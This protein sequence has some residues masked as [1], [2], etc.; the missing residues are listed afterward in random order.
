MKL[1][2]TKNQY[3][4]LLKMIYLGNWMGASAAD[5]TTKEF[6]DFEQYALSL[7][8]DFGFHGYVGF[9]E[10]ENTH[11]PTEEFEEKT[12]VVDI[13]GD[14]NMHTV[15]EEMVLSLARRDLV[16]QY[17]EE[18]VQE[19]ADEELM[20]KEYPFV[21]KYEEEFRDRG[22]QNLVISTKG[23]HLA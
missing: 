16:A 23:L 22:F 7:A 12:G 18:K 4:T 2:I 9:D 8:K 5:E 19:M 11:Y 21:L 1:D 17:G 13:I 10:N 20:E 6:D 3:E 15:W 14:Y